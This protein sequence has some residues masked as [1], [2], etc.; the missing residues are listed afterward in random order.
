MNTQLTNTNGGA[1][2]MSQIESVIINGD[3]S[4]LTPDQRVGYYKAVCESVGLNPLTKPFSYL[5]LSGKLVLYANKDCTEQ[6]RA[7]RRISLRITDRQVIDDVYVVTAEATDAT[8][9]T[10]TAT[11][12]VAL[13]ALKGEAKANAFMKAETKAKRRVTLSIAGLGM[14]DESEVTSIPGA[15]PFND[16][17]VLAPILEERADMETGEIVDDQPAPRDYATITDEQA[18]IITNAAKAAELPLATLCTAYSISDI[19]DLHAENFGRA[20]ERIEK[21]ARN[22]AKKAVQS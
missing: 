8:G 21:Y 11:G 22:R 10:D 13:G 15:K 18:G 17:P 7:A 9:R 12:A 19:H 6:L 16:E 3:L 14:L 4:K 20:M 1:P 5:T 2:A